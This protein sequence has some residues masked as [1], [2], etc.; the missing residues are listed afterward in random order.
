M[1]VLNYFS[2]TTIDP[3]ITV[4]CYYNILKREVRSQ[5]LSSISTCMTVLSSHIMKEM[6]SSNSFA[7]I[8]VAQAPGIKSRINIIFSRGI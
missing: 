2:G 6:M 5:S 4:L 3:I 1:E 8:M 7:R